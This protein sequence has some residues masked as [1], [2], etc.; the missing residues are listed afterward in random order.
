MKFDSDKK[1]AI[2]AK[3]KIQTINQLGL[4]T[5]FINPVNG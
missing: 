4:S 1:T 2:T 5:Q 3:I